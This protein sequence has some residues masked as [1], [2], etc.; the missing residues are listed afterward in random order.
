MA[1]SLWQA[2]QDEVDKQRGESQPGGQGGRGPN[3][4]AV[5]AETPES[6]RK[7]VRN[8]ERT[9]GQVDTRT[10]VRPS[11]RPDGRPSGCPDVRPLHRRPYDFY[12]DQVFWLKETKLEIEKRYGQTIQPN[13][14]VRLALDL[15]IEDYQRQRR[16][17]EA[18]S[19]ARF[20]TR[21]RTGGQRPP[22]RPD[23]RTRTHHDQSQPPFP[24]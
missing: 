11:E 4:A 3:P 12:R 17:I 16:K 21:R 10:S 13:A 14:I 23:V 22:V 9:A 15:L 2:V 5:Q 24:L 8:E 6:V 18:R 19:E 20:R 7:T 1:E